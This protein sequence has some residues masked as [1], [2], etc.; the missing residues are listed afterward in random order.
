MRETKPF[1]R[2]SFRRSSSREGQFAA[3]TG[4]QQPRP[5]VTCRTLYVLRFTFYAVLLST[6]FPTPAADLTKLPPP[7]TVQVDFDRDIKPIFESTCFRCHGTERPKSKFSLATR[8][9]AL[10]GGE[11]NTDDIV[12]GDSAKSHLIHYVARLVEDMEMPPPGKGDPLTRDQVSL[13]RAWIDQGAP[14]SKGPPPVQSLFSLSPTVRWISVD[15]NE[16]KFREHW[17][18]KDG[19]GGGVQS[20]LWQERFGENGKIIAEG[21]VLEPAHDYGIKLSVEKP[22]LGFARVGYDQF[23]RYFDDTGGY[24]EPFGAQPFSLDRDLHLDVGR[25]WIDLGLTLPDW[26]KMAL[27]YEYHFRHGARSTLQWGPV[28]GSPGGPRAIY[29]SYKVIDEKTH[30]IKFDLSHEVGG[31]LIE[32]NFRGEFYH[33]QTSRPNVEGYTLGGTVADPLTRYDEGYRHFNG[34]NTLRLEKQLREWLFVSGGYLFSKLDGDGAFRMESFFPIDPSAPSVL[35]DTSNEILLRRDSHVFNA[36]TQLGPWEGLTFASGVQSEWTRQEGFGDATILRPSVGDRVP[37]FY[38]ADLDRATVEE[39]FGLRYTKIPFTVLYADSRFQQESIGHFERQGI[40]DGSDD[41]QDFL[42]DTDATSD[43]KEAKAGVTV[44]PWTWFTWQASYK[45]RLKQNDFAHVRDTDATT[46]SVPGDGYP[47]FIRSRDLTTDQFETKLVLRPLAWLKTTVKYQLVA[48][49]YETVTDPIDDG[50]ARGV[51]V[52]GGRIFAGNYDAH[53]YSV[54][55]T[56]TPWRRLYLSTTFSLSRTR[57]T[58]GV[59]NGAQV[60]P[61]EGDVYSV[62]SSA[63]FV[64]SQ[65]TDWHASHSFSRADYGQNNFADGLPLGVAYDRHGVLTGLTRR[66]KHN[67]ATTLQY[68]FFRYAEPTAGGANDY[69]AHALFATLTK[70]GI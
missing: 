34:A 51:F 19:W 52:S 54:N 65:S 50:T 25:A 38:R 13:F 4:R 60:V 22:D 24:Y 61:F 46:F 18:T 49:D 68:G 27:G 39:N 45:H 44:S 2:S 43:L 26:P 33:L 28:F 31:V 9:S 37:A 58:T 70:S 30:I 42:R 3:A 56:L 53:V 8:E 5:F 17:W 41:P 48:T 11:N 10:R 47:A 69:T 35:G 62:L 32:D 16:R 7:A 55:T 59:N 20:A 1:L 23:R 6:A 12:P 63:N 66:F 64:L 57:L 15:G 40:E 29:P 67:L 36:N 14:W 21:R